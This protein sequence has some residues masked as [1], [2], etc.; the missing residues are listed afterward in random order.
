[1]KKQRDP[2]RGQLNRRGARVW[3]DEENPTGPLPEQIEVE[4]E[5]KE[6]QP[7]SDVTAKPDAASPAN[8][9]PGG[10]GATESDGR[11]KE[12]EGMHGGPNRKG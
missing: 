8:S 5:E 7:P 11:A 9:G 4:E 2:G 6:E 12:H 1:M 10:G 3:R